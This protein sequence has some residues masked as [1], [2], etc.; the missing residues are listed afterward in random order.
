MLP[1]AQEHGI[2]VLA[3]KTMASGH[4]LSSGVVEPVEC[5]HYAMN[6][7]VSVVIAGCDTYAIFQQALEA[8]RTFR[9]LSQEEVGTLLARTA[10]AAGAGEFEPFKVTHTYDGTMR[11]PEWL[12]L[13][14]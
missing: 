5:L 3:M 1:V 14:G 2:G 10:E 12:G 8:V 4:L 11:H 9:P 13:K 7:P 6:L